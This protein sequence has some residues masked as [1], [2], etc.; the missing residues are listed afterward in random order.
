MY[1]LAKSTLALTAGFLVALVLG[2]IIVPFLRRKKMGQITSKFVKEHAQKAGTPVMGGLIFIFSTIIVL[3][4]LLLTKKITY[5]SNLTIIL[6]VFLSYALLGFIDDYRIIK[7]KSNEKGLTRL[8]KFI[9]QVIIAVGFFLLYVKNGM[10]PTIEIYLFDIKLNLGMFYV[11]FILFMLVGSSNAVNLTD[12]LDGLAGGLSVI[13]F[14]VY[15]MIAWN[16]GWLAGYDNIALFCFILVGGLL[17]FLVFNGYPAKIFMGD[18]G[19]LAL[20]ATLAT[21]AILTH[22]ELSLAIVGGVFV[23]ECLSVIIQIASVKIT[24]KRVFPKTP[25]HHSFQIKGWQEPNIVKLFYVVGFL[26]GIVGIL[27]GVWF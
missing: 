3:A 2:A 24:G 27:Y 20:G 18:T 26:L 16:T 13:A 25:I 12:G 19:S 17:G 1:I 14:L 15:G 9:G 10:D 21:V 23:I 22:R 6:F 4:I 7:Y 5:T 11:I 8:Q